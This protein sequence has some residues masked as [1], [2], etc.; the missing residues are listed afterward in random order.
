MEQAV[1]SG[2]EVIQAIA[3]LLSS[4]WTFLQSVTVPGL[5]FSFAT[6]LVGLFLANLG[7][8]FLGMILGTTF[9][10]EDVAKAED[11]GVLKRKDKT[12]KIGF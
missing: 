7:L 8:R 12:G 10:H 5:G 2:N 9:G 11:S 6:L 1:T 4:G 3:W